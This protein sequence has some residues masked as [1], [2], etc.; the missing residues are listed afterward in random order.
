VRRLYPPGGIDWVQ[1]FASRADEDDVV[2]RFAALFHPDFE[3]V[4]SGVA[5]AKRS[6]VGFAAYR[7][8]LRESMREFSFFRILPERFIDLGTRVLVLVRREACTHD[9]EEFGGE[10]AALFE[11]KDG[12]IYRL[13]LFTSRDEARRAA[14]L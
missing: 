6:H 12:L 8:A 10:G 2:A 13:E 14:G 7:R 5:G 1:V 11:L 9:G 4:G 3:V